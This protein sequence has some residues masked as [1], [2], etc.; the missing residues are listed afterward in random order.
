MNEHLAPLTTY[1]TVVFSAALALAVAYWLLVILGAVDLDDGGGHEGVLDALAAKGDAAAHAAGAMHDGALDA[2]AAKAD[3]AAHATG[4]LD[5][6]GLDEAAAAGAFSLRRAPVSVTASFVALFG[7]IVS[8]LAMHFAGPLATRLMPE[9]WF[10]TAVLVASLGVALPLTSFATR[11][12]ERLFRTN[13]GRK[14]DELVGSLCQVRSGRVDGGFGQAVLQDEG[15]ELLLD[16]R[17]EVGGERIGEP[18]PPMKRGDW[19]I[20]IG[21]DEE[22]SAYLV[23]PYGELVDEVLPGG[24]SRTREVD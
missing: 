16:V 8:Y 12:F 24:A 6:P 11:P 7:F 21:Y 2:L 4:D 15:A 18:P 20:I 17:V 10:G 5:V 19:A 22:R 14:R 9:A 1:P 23:E 13:E 3:A